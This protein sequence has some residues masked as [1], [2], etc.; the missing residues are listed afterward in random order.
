[1]KKIFILFIISLLLLFYVFT[2]TSLAQVEELK[3]GVY[4]AKDLNL[5]INRTYDVQNISA[6]EDIF[7]LIF[8][9]NENLQQSLRLK[10]KSQKYKLLPFREDYKILIVG[11][12]EVSLS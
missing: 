9:G 1:M 6:N 3:E 11:S 12:G 7:M 2:A 10:A 4:K 8:D 5:L